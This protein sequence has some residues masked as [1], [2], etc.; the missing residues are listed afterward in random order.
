MRI[1]HDLRQ[2]V[3][4]FRL[5]FRKGILKRLEGFGGFFDHQVIRR[6]RQGNAGCQVPCLLRRQAGH[7][8]MTA[9]VQQ[10]F[11]RET[12]ECSAWRAP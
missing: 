5:A 2:F 3:Q 7:I 12:G 11:Q 8:H 6:M 9:H 4:R 1:Q 10:F